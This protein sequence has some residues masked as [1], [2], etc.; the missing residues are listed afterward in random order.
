MNSMKQIVK[1]AQ[2]LLLSA[3]LFCAW[4]CMSDFDAINRN[5]SEATDEELGRE[6]YKISTNLRGLQNWVIPVQE[7][8]YQFNESLTGNP[9]AGYMAET[10]DGWK[11]KFS[12]FNPSADW[13][14]WPFVIVMQEVYPYFRGVVNNTEDE[15]AIALA[16]LFR[17]AIMH[18]MTD[19]YGPIPYSKVIEDSSESLT[20][21]Y[22]SQETVYMKMFEE[23]DAV[24]AALHA[25]EQMSAEAF[26]KSDNVYYGDIKKWIK[27]ANSLKL[28]MAMRLSYVKS[29]IAQKK[30]EEAV[31]D[32]V[33]LDNAD[34]AYMHAPENRVALIYND[35]GDHRVG[36]DILCYMN[37]YKDPR[38]EKMFLA[39]DVGDYVGI[40]IGIDVTSK[41]QAMSKYSNM[42]VASD[43]PYLWFNAAEATFLHAE[44]ELRW[45]SAETAK[46]LYE[47]A[48][49]L[50]FEERGASGADAYLVDATKKPAPYTDPLGNYSA[51]ARSEIT[52]PW[53]T[54][55]D[56]SDTEAVQERNLERIIVQ[57]WIAIFPL[58]VEAWSE[59]RRTGYP[60]LLPVPTDKSGG[61]V[62]VEQGARRL[63]YPV[64]EYQQNNANLQ[65]AIQTLGAEQQ[66][67]DRSGDVMG[68]R[69]WWDCKPYNK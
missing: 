46:T 7:H 49:R 17:I 40:R 18:R 67:G 25:N 59:H 36:A 38:M 53:E 34:N 27:Y 66:N 29:D 60:K 52:V 54:A 26:R 2:F 4:G 65:A 14:K 19:T 55:T 22:D 10:P 41:S 57:K 16:R 44:Y 63:P 32:G 64:E 21:A 13:L 28:R 51:S 68:T 62:N 12:T 37:G 45:G 20:V 43:T 5:P 15:A 50:S 6:N 42:I 8:R 24:I 31:A 9:Y 33:I 3:V 39:N 69:V 35:W 58:G 11:E 56:G 48:V 30:A 23:L 1:T 47:Q 61:S